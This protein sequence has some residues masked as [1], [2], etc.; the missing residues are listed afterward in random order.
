MQPPG[1]NILFRYGLIGISFFLL[2]LVITILVLTLTKD[3]SSSEPSSPITT[4]TLDS[5]VSKTRVISGTIMYVDPAGE[6]LRVAVPGEGVFSVGVAEMSTVDIDGKEISISDLEPM[7]TITVTTDVLP[8]TDR[9][10]YVIQEEAAV[11]ITTSGAVGE[12]EELSVEERIERLR[13]L[14]SDSVSE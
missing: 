8:N 9:Y 7:S 11:E 12:A 14:T 10:D 5:D 1:I 13:Q 2:L 6:Y 4:E 3:E